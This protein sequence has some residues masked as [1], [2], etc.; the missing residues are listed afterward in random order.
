MLSP[1][2]PILTFLQVKGEDGRYNVPYKVQYRNKLFK[3]LI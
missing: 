1:H 2:I 3:P